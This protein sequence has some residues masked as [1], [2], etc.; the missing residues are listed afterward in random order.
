MVKWISTLLGSSIRVVPDVVLAAAGPVA[1]LAR[2]ASYGADS[3]LGL[4]LCSLAGGWGRI[5]SVSCCS[6]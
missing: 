2:L 1:S 5:L 6:S 4:A 3:D